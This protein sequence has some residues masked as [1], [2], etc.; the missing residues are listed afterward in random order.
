MGFYETEMLEVRCTYHIH[1]QPWR[2]NPRSI[3]FD[4]FYAVVLDCITS[5]EPGPSMTNIAGTVHTSEDSQ[6]ALA[7]KHWGPSQKPPSCTHRD[8]SIT[9][10]EHV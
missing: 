3:R 9:P 6:A 5:V 8:K 1:K 7:Q 2:P 4:A 10:Y